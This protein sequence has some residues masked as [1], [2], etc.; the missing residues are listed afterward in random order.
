MSFKCNLL[1]FLLWKMPNIK[2]SWYNSITNP[3]M[4]SFNWSAHGPFTSPFRP[5]SFWNIYHF[6]Y[7]YFRLLV[8]NNCLKIYNNALAGVARWVPAC[9][10][11]GRWFNSQSGHMPGLWT[12]SQVGD[13]W[14]ATTHWCFSP[15]LSPSFPLSLK[16]L[17]YI[18]IY[19]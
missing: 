15:F 17:I 16:K 7:K 13:V 14:E 8:Y 4:S 6:T 1:N 12:R 10:P 2:K 18:Y 9:E 11:K 19:I 3:L 5:P